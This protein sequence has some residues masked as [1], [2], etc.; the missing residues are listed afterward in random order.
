V[1]PAHGPGV[2]YESR[3]AGAWV[4]LLPVR[5]DA[6]RWQ[7][8][9]LAQW[10]PGSPALES[11]F[12]RIGHGPAFSPAQALASTAR[13]GHLTEQC[14]GADAHGNAGAVVDMG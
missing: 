8:E 4:A 11:Y 5:F 7:R 1:L 2:L 12:Q 6:D 3:L 9:F 14:Q 13:Q 10:P